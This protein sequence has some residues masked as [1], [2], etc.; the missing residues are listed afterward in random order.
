[1]STDATLWQRFGQLP[2]A[3][4]WA[5]YAAVGMGGFVVVNDHVWKQ[6]AEWRHEADEIQAQLQDV[7]DGRSIA[8]KLLKMLD[9]IVAHGP[10]SIPDPDDA[11]AG[12]DAFN[13]TVTAVLKAHSVRNDSFDR[14]DLSKLKLDHASF[15]PAGQEAHYISGDLRFEASPDEAIAVIAELESS[16]DI[17]AVTSVRMTRPGSARRVKVQVTLEAWVLTAA[18]SSKKRKA[19]GS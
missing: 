16:P 2:R 10:V 11:E 8:D 13:A 4:Q 5:V 15:V 3:L 1:M 9:T 12:S 18:K 7:H 6:A 19:G 17:E 14:R